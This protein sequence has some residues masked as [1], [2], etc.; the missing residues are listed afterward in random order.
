MPTATLARRS[1]EAQHSDPVALVLRELETD[2]YAVALARICAV[3]RREA[4]GLPRAG[5]GS[6]YR[7]AFNA[8][9]DAFMTCRDELDN[10]IF[11]AA[12]SHDLERSDLPSTA[13]IVDRLAA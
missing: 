9:L 12:R 8:C 4:A 5:T 3:A 7:A 11:E 2:G 10:L 1:F 6:P 13:E